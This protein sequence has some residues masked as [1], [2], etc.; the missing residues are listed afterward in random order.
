MIAH[1]AALALVPFWPS[2]HAPIGDGGSVV[3]QVDAPPGSWQIRRSARAI[4]AQVDGVTVRTSGDCS[5]ADAC[6]RV[7]VDAFDPPTMLA[8]SEGVEDRW[9]GLTTYP[10]ERVIYLNTTTPRYDREHTAA[11]EFGHA[12]GLA[13]MRSRGL[14]STKRSTDDLHPRE[15]AL[16]ES[17]YR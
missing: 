12:I 4:A 8:L 6:V 16:L 5:T 13:H 3:V 11:H 2:W 10:G 14:M 1:L 7:V 15:V 17:W 9:Y